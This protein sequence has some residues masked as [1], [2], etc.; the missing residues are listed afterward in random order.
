MMTQMIF[1]TT[2]INTNMNTR[3]K[4]RKILMMITS[5]THQAS[6][7]ATEDG[8]TMGISGQVARRQS[9]FISPTPVTLLLGP[10]VTASTKRLRGS[11]MPARRKSL[12]K[13]KLERI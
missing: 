13:R 12:R 6:E 10:P 5:I 3:R 1:S 11:Q 9:L 8:E 2:N 4:M 7:S